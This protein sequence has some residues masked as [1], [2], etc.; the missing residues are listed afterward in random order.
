MNRCMY[1]KSNVVNL[2]HTSALFFPLLP[3][4]S[5]YYRSSSYPL[6]LPPTPSPTLIRLFTPFDPLLAYVY[7]YDLAIVNV[8]YMLLYLLT[9]WLYQMNILLKSN[10]YFYYLVRDCSLPNVQCVTRIWY[11][12]LNK[13][14]IACAYTRTD[15]HIH[16]DIEHVHTRAGTRD[17]K[18]VV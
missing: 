17:R 3:S 6:P 16:T 10:N 8:M 18:S 15:T 14:Q 2:A 13:L 12:R 4:F 11:L 5:H 1:V 9:R 7:T